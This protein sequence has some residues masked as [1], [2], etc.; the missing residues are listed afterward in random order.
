[1]IYSVSVWKIQSAYFSD[2]L[3]K[4]LKLEATEHNFFC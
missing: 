2:C 1:M 3:I 4:L